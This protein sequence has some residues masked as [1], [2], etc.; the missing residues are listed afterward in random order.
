[1][2]GFEL[3]TSGQVIGARSLRI[4][5]QIFRGETRAATVLNEEFA[6]NRTS[7]CCMTGN[8]EITS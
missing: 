1:V 6:G 3:T 7:S 4:F 5:R 8:S 2:A